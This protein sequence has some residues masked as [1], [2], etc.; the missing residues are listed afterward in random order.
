MKDL[1]IRHRLTF[2]PVFAQA[3]RHRFQVQQLQETGRT[4]PVPP[5]TP[6]DVRKWIDAV[7]ARATEDLLSEHYE[8]V[9]AVALTRNRF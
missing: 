9:A 5:V 3:L 2:A 6:E 7:V 8:H 4:T 1:I